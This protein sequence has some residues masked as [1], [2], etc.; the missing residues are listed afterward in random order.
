M[1]GSETKRTP[2]KWNAMRRRAVK[3]RKQNAER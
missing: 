3:K 1:S 2:A